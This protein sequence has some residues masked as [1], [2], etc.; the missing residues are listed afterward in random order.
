MSCEYRQSTCSKV[1]RS[2]CLEWNAVCLVCR[3]VADVELM[4]L[5][6][7]NKRLWLKISHRRLL[8]N[9]ILS[10]TIDWM[11]WFLVF[12]VVSCVAALSIKEMLTESLA[13]DIHVVT[14]LYIQFTVH[15]DDRLYIK[16]GHNQCDVKHWHLNFAFWR[17]NV[18]M[19]PE[20][21]ISGVLSD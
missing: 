14:I 13:N 4:M 11:L 20:V 1:H 8:K 21:T 9:Q 6:K 2:T 7:K 5:E 18:I 15:S 16:A 10:C 3:W 19:A 12:L 17:P